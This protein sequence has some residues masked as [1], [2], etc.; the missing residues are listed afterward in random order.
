MRV[1]RYLSAKE[2]KNIQL[3][4]ISDIGSEYDDDDYKRCEK[5]ENNELFT[6]W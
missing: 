2:L 4:N 3:N 1:Y 6:L 5:N